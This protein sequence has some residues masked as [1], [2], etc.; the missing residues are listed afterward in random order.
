MLHWEPVQPLRAGMEKTYG[1]IE[2]EVIKARSRNSGP[3]NNSRLGAYRS[4]L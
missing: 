3:V 2:S 4:A 1:W